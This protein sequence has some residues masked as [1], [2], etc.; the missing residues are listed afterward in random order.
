MCNHDQVM[1]NFPNRALEMK[2][3]GRF[4]KTKVSTFTVGRNE[5][6]KFFRTHSHRAVLIITIYLT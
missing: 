5:V 4:D 1:N 6:V 3:N 2:Q